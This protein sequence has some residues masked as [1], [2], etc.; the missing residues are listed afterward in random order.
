MVR[1]HL[2]KIIQSNNII[3]LEI[4]LDYSKQLWKNRKLSPLAQKEK[5]KREKRGGRERRF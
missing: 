3:F 1:I 2:L 5:K 4:K